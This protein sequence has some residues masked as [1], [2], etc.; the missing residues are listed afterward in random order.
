LQKGIFNTLGV[1]PRVY[2]TH[3]RPGKRRQASVVTNWTTA[4]RSQGPTRQKRPAP[5]S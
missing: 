5:M 3:I 1:P 4:K 2:H